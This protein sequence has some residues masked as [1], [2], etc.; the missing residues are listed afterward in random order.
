MA[1]D[2]DEA[3]PDF[4]AALASLASASTRADV[5]LAEAPAP[6][7]IAPFAVAITGQLQ[8]ADAEASGRFILLHD[9]AGHDAWEGT[10]RIVAM[11]KAEV[12]PEIGGDDMWADVAW[13]WLS[14]S[15]EDVPHHA[16]GGTVTKVSDRSFGNLDERADE[17]HVEVRVSWTPEGT[18]MAPHVRA[19]TDLLAA[20][21]GVPDL[22]E[23]VTMLP[24]RHA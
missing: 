10:F 19:W 7:R 22:P 5:V 6:G 8:T 16:R 11:V 13:S 12:E 3:P 2:F 24:G 4:R 18:D 20:C 23:G 9:P 14:E 1:Q 15:L 21:A 17:V